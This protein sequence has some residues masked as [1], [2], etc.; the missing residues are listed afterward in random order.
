MGIA[1]L[2]LN[3]TLLECVLQATTEGLAMTGIEPDAVGVSR[4]S[5]LGRQLSI[6]LGLHGKLNG[7]VT[8]NMSE[9]TARF[10][11]G[12]FLGMELETFD[13]DVID[14]ICELG[15][16]VAG[17]MKTI[18]AD[19][20]FAFED[21]SLPALIVGSSYNLYH[22]KNINVVSVTF[23]IKE[24]PVVQVKDKFFTVTMAMEVK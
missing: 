6:I 16:I 18:L 1:D 12:R 7:H 22:H 17:M 3:Q 11:S 23:E 10:L 20:E 13:E 9:N 8:L 5:N 19:T 21:L 4:F 14:A 24:I 2:N 15:N